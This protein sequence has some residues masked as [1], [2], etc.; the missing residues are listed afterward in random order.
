MLLFYF[1]FVFAMCL[2]ICF[3]C[4]FLFLCLLFMCMCEGREV[5]SQQ[6]LVKLHVVFLM[7]VGHKGRRAQEQQRFLIYK[8]VNCMGGG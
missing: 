1:I 3:F 4:F 8:S 7:L 5:L 2:F 6:D